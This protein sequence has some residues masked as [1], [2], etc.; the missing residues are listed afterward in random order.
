MSK[1]NKTY[2]SEEDKRTVCEE[3]LSSRESI[4]Q[5]ARRNGLNKGRLYNWLKDKRYNPSPK[6][7]IDAPEPTAF[8]PVSVENATVFEKSA[9]ECSPN[10]VVSNS[11]LVMEIR[12][13]AGHEVR[14]SGCLNEQQ[15]TAVLAGLAT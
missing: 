3:A 5:V 8:V 9:P 13:V 6:P 1:K 7:A 10:F 11:E 14:L 15:L 12:L 4:A 2:W